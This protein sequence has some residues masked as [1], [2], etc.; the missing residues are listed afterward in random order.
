MS[1]ETYI[2]PFQEK[3]IYTSDFIVVV[4]YQRVLLPLKFDVIHFSEL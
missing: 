2:I 3:V 1:W 4:K